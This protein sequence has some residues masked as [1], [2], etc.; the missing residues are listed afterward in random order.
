MGQPVPEV[1]LTDLDGRPVEFALLVGKRSLV[2]FWNPD[3]GF[4]Q[5]MVPEL[6]AYEAAPPA[7]APPII[8]ISAGDPDRVRAQGFTSPVLLDPGGHCARA[9]GAGG[10]PMG[11]LVT[12]GRIDSG[13]AA[14]AT[15]VLELAAASA[16]STGS[17]V[18]E[19]AAQ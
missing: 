9:F 1:A 17:T 10:T 4:C 8:V 19:G 7:G 3:C 2:L 15:A 11:V 12:G 18:A 6:H 5:R 16:G 13:V 14:G